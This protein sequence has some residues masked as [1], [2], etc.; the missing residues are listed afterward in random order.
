M[1]TI[2]IIGE[3]NESLTKEVLDKILHIEKEDCEILEVNEKLANE[4]DKQE[5]EDLV[6]NIT[7]PGGLTYGAMAI[8]DALTGLSC[9]I[10]TRGFGLCA[11]GGF[12]ILLAGDTKL[13]CENTEF[14]YHTMAYGS[15][16]EKLYNHVDYA[17]H[18]IKLQDKLDK[19]V[20]DNTKITRD[21]LKNRKKDDWFMLIDE[22]L[23]L[24]IIDEII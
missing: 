16:Y 2:N 13:A 21:M 5:L 14:L 6:V 8:Y 1:R 17:D 10:I 12:W 19:I 11:S 15:R 18:N 20:I 4:E 24:G 22:A 9:N 3:I 7:C 23:E